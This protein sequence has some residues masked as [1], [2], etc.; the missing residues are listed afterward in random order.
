MIII[1]QA[2]NFAAGIHS[3]ESSKGIF[4][5]DGLALFKKLPSQKE[6]GRCPIK[7]Q[8]SSKQY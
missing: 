5:F 1:Y 6:G 2:W 7:P 4:L 3:R 8:P